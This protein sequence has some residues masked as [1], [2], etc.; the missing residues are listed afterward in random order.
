MLLDVLL[1]R[2]RWTLFEWNIEWR[3][4]TIKV[5]DNDGG[6]GNGVSLWFMAVRAIS[7]AISRDGALVYVSF[8]LFVFVGYSSV[9]RRCFEL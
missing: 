2:K 1:H 3:T 8:F 4:R 9:D 6:E 7:M 5:E